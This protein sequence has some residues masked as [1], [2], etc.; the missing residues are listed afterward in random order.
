MAVSKPE[1]LK[2]KIPSGIELQTF[3]KIAI[4]LDKAGLHTVCH[5]AKCPNA[6]ECWSSGTATFLILG[7]T[8][9][10]HCGFCNVKSAKEGKKIDESEPKKIAKAVKEWNLKYGVLTSVDRDDL[11]DFGSR[12]FA[13]CI[14][15]IKKE[16]PDVLVEVLIPDFQGKI[17]FLETVVKAKPN[18][19]AHNIETV[20]E[21]QSNVRD[22]KANYETSLRVLEN[23][24]KL[25]EKI[26]TKSSIMLGLDET[27]EQILSAM[28]DLRNAGV[29]FLAIGQYLQPSKKNL[30]VQRFVSL[31]EF[32][33]YKSEGKKLGFKFVA[34]APFV[35]T[36]Y[37][38]FEFF[39]NKEKR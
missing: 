13:E 23:V 16:C 33:F 24:K 12:H 9:T 39:L 34:S 8:C 37:K 36:S 11:A 19:I 1:W 10:R 3:N 2:V 14:L 20:K 28:N 35:R 6:F 21:L 17:E 38:A 26:F 15:E 30:P 22:K 5:E 25:D 27:K 29:D 32:D 7:D 31:E 4:A 18:V